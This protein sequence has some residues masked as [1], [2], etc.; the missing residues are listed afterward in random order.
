ML[1]A[2]DIAG[3][4]VRVLIDGRYDVGRHSVVLDGRD[5]L[6]RNASGVYISRL[7]SGERAI[8]RRM[9]LVR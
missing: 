6:G 4:V 3:R 7:T 8:T 5:D 2:Y 9:V 1:A